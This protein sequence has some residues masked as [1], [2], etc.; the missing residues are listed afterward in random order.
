[1]TWLLLQDASGTKGNAKTTDE[2]AVKKKKLETASFSFLLKRKSKV[3]PGQVGS[4]TEG[5]HGK[6]DEPKPVPVEP[7]AGDTAQDAPADGKA[8]VQKE[9]VET[10]AETDIK[11]IAGAED[12]D[13][14]DVDTW[15]LLR[16]LPGG[17][18]HG[19]G[20]GHG[21]AVVLLPGFAITW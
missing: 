19:Y 6:K 3:H 12:P 7:V 2:S 21:G 15:S 17:F 20:S 16:S 18:Q 5:A 9:A 13:S 8:T 10:P 4:F 14:S 1:M 11:Q